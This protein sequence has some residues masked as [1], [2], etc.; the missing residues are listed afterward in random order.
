VKRASGSGISGSIDLYEYSSS[1]TPRVERVLIVIIH[2]TNL[3]VY[4]D[5]PLGVNTKKKNLRSSSQ[6]GVLE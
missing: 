6:V 1:S 5:A 4:G 2:K 3:D